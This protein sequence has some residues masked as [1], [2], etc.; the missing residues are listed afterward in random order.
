MP[1]TKNGPGVTLVAVGVVL[2]L[3]GLLSFLA[4]PAAA[5]MDEKEA[6]QEGTRR[7][8]VRRQRLVKGAT[9]TTLVGAALTAVGTTMVLR[10]R[11]SGERLAGK[12]SSKEL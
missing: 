9:A 2:A 11:R 7:G 1:Q 10:E 5:H 8:D 3:A 4:L 12:P 6:Y